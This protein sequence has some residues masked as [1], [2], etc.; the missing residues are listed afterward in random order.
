MGS[1]S[2][3]WSFLD[4]HSAPSIPPPPT[5]ILAKLPQPTFAQTL[6]SVCDVPASQL[7][8]PIVKGDRLFIA[9]PEEEYLEGMVTCKHNLHGRVIWPKGSSPLKVDALRNKLLTAWKDLGRWGITSLGKGFYEFVFSSLEDVQKV[10]SAGSWNLNPGLLKLFAWSR[11]FNPN[12]Q[13]QTSAQVWVRIHGLSQEYWRPKI[14]FAIASSVGTPIC[15]DAASVKSPFDRP[16]SHFARVLVDMDLKTNLRYK[17]LVERKDFAFFVDLEYENMPD[18]CDNCM[19]IGHHRSYCKKHP[20]IVNTAENS[21][22]NKPTKKTFVVVKNPK[23]K[24]GTVEIENVP[25]KN[26]IDVPAVTDKPSAA[27]TTIPIL[28]SSPVQTPTPPVSVGQQ[29]ALENNDGFINV[30]DSPEINDSISDSDFV[31]ATQDDEVGQ[32][33]PVISSSNNIPVMVQNDIN[34]LKNSWA[35]MADL[36]D[37][38]ELFQQDFENLEIPFQPVISKASKKAARKKNVASKSPYTTRSRGG[39]SKG[40]Q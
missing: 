32:R 5:E 8:Q 20:V 33:S 34:F 16:F 31:D 21:D 13:H 3:P 37:N 1:F 4:G 19:V 15:T 38:T 26:V 6:S 28:N 40:A 24:Q 11:D 12:L 25:V 10:R 18:F 9:I 30:E 7:P 35:N 22:K 36:E 14:L 2:I 29:V 23:P 39:H 27:D 17:V